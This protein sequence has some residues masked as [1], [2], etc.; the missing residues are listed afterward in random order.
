VAAWLAV[1]ALAGYLAGLALH[2]PLL[3][4]VCKPVPVLVLAAKVFRAGPLPAARAVGG[5][6][7][8]SALG[9]VL[10]EGRGLFV[11]GLSAFLLAH[12]AYT[13]AF[14][15]D[16]RRL[17]WARALP[18][19]VWLGAAGALVWPGLGALTLPVGVY[20]IA[21]GA[22]MWRAAARVDPGRAGALLGCGG[23]VLFGL[24]DTLIALDRFRA[25]IEGV[26]YP[27]ILLYWAGQA[28]IAWSV[29]RPPVVPLA[30]A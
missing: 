9:D 1:G 16:E 14:L 18:F 17:R 3:C 26:R 4:L 13:A 11:A 10:L 30:A 23:A 21:I 28:G 29:R 6:L 15:A 20:M 2:L 8:L 27:I 7:L 25:P 5:G 19:V 24:S 12:L 22:M